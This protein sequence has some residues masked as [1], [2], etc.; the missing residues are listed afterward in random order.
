MPSGLSRIP[1]AQ[2]V[3]SGYG[4][5]YAY[6]YGG[7]SIA[8]YTQEYIAPFPQ[9][10]ATS[11]RLVEGR[12]VP[13]QYQSDGSL[14][15]A[16]KPFKLMNLPSGTADYDPAGTGN[17]K[18]T[19]WDGTGSGYGEGDAVFDVTYRPLNFE[20]RSDSEI[21]ALDAPLNSCELGRYVFREYKFGA[22]VLTFPKGQAYFREDLQ[23]N[24]FSKPI[25]E[26]ACLKT[27][28]FGTWVYH[29]YHVPVIPWANIWN[30]YGKINDTEVGAGA[31]GGV[32]D[33]RPSIGGTSWING[34]SS[35][36]LPG[37][38]LFEG[39]CGLEPVLSAAGQYLWNISYAF[40]YLPGKD[41]ATND[42]HNMVYKFTASDFKEVIANYTPG[43]A[44]G[45]W[46]NIY[47]KAKFTTLFQ[48]PYT[49]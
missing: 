21:A 20:V 47:D 3:G 26:S 43:L 48:I 8:T 30:A 15:Y 35:G 9:W 22:R 46:K 27:L 31:P 29:W 42:T 6:P 13:L 36:W 18:G 24:D 39:V 1:P 11:A 17:L 34:K 14:T 28:P 4:A 41:G 33:Y 49:A 25:P 23:A 2:P 12:S 16:N 10:Y 40:R 32:F 38:L 44:S 5:G 19:I 37:T 7:S 45:S